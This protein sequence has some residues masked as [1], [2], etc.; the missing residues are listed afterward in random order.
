MKNTIETA[1]E[2]SISFDEYVALFD[3]LVKEGKTTGPNQSEGYISFTKLNWSR[4][5]RALKQIELDQATLHVLAEIKEPLTLLIITE[6][7][8]GDASQVLPVIQLMDE[9]SEKI[10]S[11]LVLRDEHAALMNAFLTNGGKAIPKVIVLDE[12][13]KVLTS[14]G[15]RPSELQKQVLAYKTENPTSTGMDVSGLVQKWY[16]EDRG[17]I[18]QLELASLLQKNIHLEV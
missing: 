12:N 17:K 8:C 13:N 15:P 3:Q 9:L 2:K 11:K 4:Y 1:L 6:V 5:K 7:W 18:T 14:W 10:T 16:N